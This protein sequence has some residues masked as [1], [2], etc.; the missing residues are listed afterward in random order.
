MT[1]KIRLLGLGRYIRGIRREILLVWRIER[2]GK[3]LNMKWGKIWI[4]KI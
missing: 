4:R 3:L 2:K 1:L